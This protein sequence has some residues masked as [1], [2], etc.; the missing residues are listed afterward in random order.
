MD[1]IWFIQK[2][3]GKQVWTNYVQISNWWDYEVIIYDD[4]V[5][6]FPKNLDKTLDMQSEKKK[7]D[8]IAQYVDIK[9]PEYSIVDGVCITYPAITGIPFDKLNIPY[10]E[11]ML[12]DIALFMKQ[13]HSIPLENFWF[14]DKNEEAKQ[15]DSDKTELHTFVDGL[16]K[17]VQN[18]LLGKVPDVTIRNIHEYMDILFFEYE[19]AEKAFVHTDIQAKNII[20]DKHTQ[21]ISG[22]IDFTDSRIG[23][24]E[25]DFCHFYD[26]GEEIL[27]KM[28][29]LYRWSEDKDLFDRTFFLARRGVIF[30]IDNDDVFEN[31]LE[32]IIKQL[33][34]YKFYSE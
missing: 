2:H 16:K 28:I 18:K 23:W 26:L 9:V 17:K 13:L 20:Y 1:Y 32:Y 33:K 24:I 14:I 8:I 11:E 19:S 34:K 7:L 15:Q 25:L 3:L 12:V 5:F 29:Q 30:E 22:I 31:N 10:T 4:I 21:K 6:R 27:R